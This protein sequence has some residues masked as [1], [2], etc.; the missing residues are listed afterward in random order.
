MDRSIDAAVDDR[1]GVVGVVVI[2][3]AARQTQKHDQEYRQAEQRTKSQRGDGEKNNR[4][5]ERVQIK[6]ASESM[7]G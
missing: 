1:D 4:Q 5:T 2:V 3:V 7:R 6:R